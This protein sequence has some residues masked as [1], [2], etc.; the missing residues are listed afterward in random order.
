MKVAVFYYSG[1]GNTKYIARKL[2]YQLE[3]K[4]YDVAMIRITQKTS[5]NSIQDTD[6]YIIGFPVYDLSAPKLVTD[7]V[8][9]LKAEHKPI[10]YFCTKAFMSADSIKELH[11]I[12]K[13]KGLITVSTLDLFM[14]ATDALALF[15][16][17]GSRTEKILKSFHSKHLDKK[18]A[19]FIIRMEERKELRVSKKWYTGLAFL[20][21]KKTK[22]AFHDQ[23]TKYIPQ[24]YSRTDVCIQ[25]MLCVKGCPRENIRYDNGIKFDLNC[26]MCLAC[27]HHCPVDSI[28]LGNFTQGTVRLR[29]IEIKD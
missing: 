11:E 27:L 24:F 26:D 29:K 8:K 3:Q 5:V 18:I 14:P 9:K 13:A 4:S 23:Y 2:K 20:I 17:E 16:K 28:Q 15:A 25:C 12:S 1:A 19:A 6:F 22:K 21:P 10:S 7:L